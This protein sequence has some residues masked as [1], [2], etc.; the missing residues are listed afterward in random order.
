[1]HLGVRI[2]IDIFFDQEQCNSANS[3]VNEIV[4]SRVETDIPQS[5]ILSEFQQQVMAN[6]RSKTVI[7]NTNIITGAPAAAAAT[8]AAAAV[9]TSS[10]GSATSFNRV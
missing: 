4:G 6:N 1:M 9:T 8:A 10:S 7:N 2:I 3:N 5:R